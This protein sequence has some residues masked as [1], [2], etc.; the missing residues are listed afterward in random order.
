MFFDSESYSRADPRDQPSAEYE[1]A[2][3]RSQKAGCKL[4]S[5]FHLQGGL[6]PLSPHCHL[7]DRRVGAFL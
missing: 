3:P 1:E 2:E 6:T 4:H 7:T 5:D